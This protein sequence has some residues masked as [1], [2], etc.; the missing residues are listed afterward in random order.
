M[1]T[2]ALMLTSYLSFSTPLP[3][4]PGQSEKNIKVMNLTAS[5]S[6]CFLCGFHP[7]L[8]TLFCFPSGISCSYH[9]LMLPKEQEQ[10]KEGKKVWQLETHP[11]I[12]CS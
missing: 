4:S 3:H 11:E 8:D 1:H 5:I 12:S 7:D 9:P 10:Q 6:S 2:S